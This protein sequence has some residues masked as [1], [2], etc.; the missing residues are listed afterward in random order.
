MPKDIEQICKPEVFEKIFSTY[1]KDLKRYIFFKTQDKD[2]AED[3]LQETFIKLWDNCNGVTFSKVKSYLYTVATNIFLNHVKHNKVKKTYQRNNIR[4]STNETPEF[5]MIEKEFL[6]KIETT[7][8][9]LHPLQREV[10]LLN[11]I[12][13]KKYRE[14]AVMLEISVKA[15][16]KRMHLAL[17]EIRQKIGNV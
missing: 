4:N 6:E 13:K 8:S 15:V 7:I 16:E 1:A 10:F 11:R 5:I 12:E 3:I 2:L 17:I 14:I 9:S